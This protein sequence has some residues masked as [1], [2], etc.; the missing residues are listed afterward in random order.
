MKERSHKPEDL[1]AL[2]E[3]IIGLGE[4]SVRKSYYP[5]LRQSEE[6]YRAI[7]ELA[8]I[9]IGQMDPTN[10]QLLCVNDRFCEITGYSREELLS[11]TVQNQ[12]L[13]HPD[14]RQA[15]W[16]MY[17]RMLRE[18]T[19]EYSNE[20]RYIRKGGNVIWVYAAARAIRDAA[21]QLVSSVGILMDITERK[22][23]EAELKESERKFRDLTERSLVGVYLIQN[24]VFK[25]INPRLSEIFGYTVEEL[26]NN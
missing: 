9:G 22:S 13:T 19:P 8:S 24:G 11:T 10:G 14:D 25:Y 17:T 4:R 2:R 6:Q 15:D 23:I 20:K 5:K 21:G 7:F 18:E 12:N 16:E 3:Q 1:D 26:V